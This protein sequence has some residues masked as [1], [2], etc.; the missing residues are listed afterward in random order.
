MG[1]RMDRCCSGDVPST[2]AEFVVVL[3]GE[4]GKQVWGW[5]WCTYIP[6]EVPSTGALE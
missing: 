3:E 6:G 4:D 1:D 5:I 2:G